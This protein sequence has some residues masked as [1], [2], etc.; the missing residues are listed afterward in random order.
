MEFCFSSMPAALLNNPRLHQ[1][2][3]TKVLR[4]HSETR[5]DT[6]RNRASQGCSGLRV[7]ASSSSH[8]QDFGERSH[9]AGM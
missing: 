7:R 5:D 8:A 2:N 4:S 3:Y 6:H 9:S 1:L